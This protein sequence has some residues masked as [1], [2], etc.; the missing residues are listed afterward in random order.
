MKYVLSLLVALLFCFMSDAGYA[1][2]YATISSGPPP[3]DPLPTFVLVRLTILS[4]IFLSISLFFGAWSYRRYT[5][6]K[7]TLPKK[8]LALP[9]IFLMLG[10][11]A[12]TGTLN[13]WMDRLNYKLILICVFGFITFLCGSLIYELK[14]KNPACTTASSLKNLISNLD[15]KTIAMFVIALMLMVEAIALYYIPKHIDYIPSAA[16]LSF[17]TPDTQPRVYER[18]AEIILYSGIFFFSFI[19]SAL[20]AAHAYFK[21][22]K[23]PS[24]KTLTVIVIFLMLEMVAVTIAFSPLSDEMEARLL[25]TCFIGFIFLLIFSPIYEFRKRRMFQSTGID[26][27]AVPVKTARKTKLML[28]IALMFFIEA[29]TIQIL[30]RYLQQRFEKPSYAGPTLYRFDGSS[31]P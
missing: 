21:K 7:K 27:D 31:F 24:K 22:K 16:S 20:D 17:G 14:K 26:I 11:M 19:L 15:N 30:P 5:L 2:G 13:P 18:N 8:A 28:I 10:V 9:M 6:K 1:Q 3:P 23:R 29:M 25:T 4:S 12:A